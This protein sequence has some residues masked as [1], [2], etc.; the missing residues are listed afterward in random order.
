MKQIITIKSSTNMNHR[1]YS[2]QCQPSPPN[3]RGSNDNRGNHRETLYLDGSD[4]CLSSYGNLGRG[5]IEDE[6]TPLAPYLEN[7]REAMSSSLADDAHLES[8]QRQIDLYFA[9]NPHDSSKIISGSSGTTFTTAERQLEDWLQDKPPVNQDTIGRDKGSA[10]T[11]GAKNVVFGRSGSG[12]GRSRLVTI[13]ESLCY[14]SSSQESTIRSHQ[15]HETTIPRALAAP[16]QDMESYL[17]STGPNLK[18][19]REFVD[20][21][22]TTGLDE[23]AIDAMKMALIHDNAT[24]TSNVLALYCLTKLLVLAGKSNDNQKTMIFDLSGI[25]TFD[26][27]IETAQIYRWAADI[28]RRVCAVLWSLSIKYEKHVEQYGGC[29]VILNAMKYHIKDEALQG[30]ALGALKV[31]SF[32]SAGRSMLLSQGCLSIIT[33]VMRAHMHNPTIQSRGCVVLGNLVVDESCQS[34]RPISEK[35]VD[36]VIKGMLAHSSSLEVYEAA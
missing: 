16:A 26:A 10:A 29:K 8:L 31:M 4:H 22:E 1:H 3:G 18:A 6:Q 34:T 32:D 28:Q 19:L 15:V 13:D 17:H 33:D 25:S 23:E 5:D 14:S 2:P 27:I 36:V 21:C 7:E 12:L 30:M 11:A 35:A 20:M 24:S 9:T